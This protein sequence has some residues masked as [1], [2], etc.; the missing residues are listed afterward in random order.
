M[1]GPRGTNRYSRAS[2]IEIAATFP[3]SLGPEEERAAWLARSRSRGEAAAG[4]GSGGP[5]PL[6]RSERLERG[7]ADAR[8][9]RAERQRAAQRSRSKRLRAASLSCSFWRAAWC[10]RASLCACALR[11]A[12]SFLRS[13]NFASA[14]RPAGCGSEGCFAISLHSLDSAEDR[15]TGNAR[16]QHS[17]VEQLLP[18]YRSWPRHPAGDPAP[19][20][21][22]R[23]IAV[24]AS[25]GPRRSASVS[26]ADQ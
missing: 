6:V 4:S 2:T 25:T 10:E 8:I 15:A 19:S 12:I 13:L 24:R 3:D 18:A 26:G 9:W 11:S 21:P 1:T 16:A 7:W 14:E 17:A 20:T 23:A 22:G 5:L